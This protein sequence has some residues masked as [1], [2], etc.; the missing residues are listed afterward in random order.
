MDDRTICSSSIFCLARKAFSCSVTL[1]DGTSILKTAG[2]PPIYRIGL[3]LRWGFTIPDRD[4]FSVEDFAL[5]MT[6]RQNPGRVLDA[7]EYRSTYRIWK[8]L[9]ISLSAAQEFEHN[10]QCKH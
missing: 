8:T 5:F 2:V 3:G 1:V 7:M 6:F 4:D 9:G 10:S